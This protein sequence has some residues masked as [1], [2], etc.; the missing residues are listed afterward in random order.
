MAQENKAQQDKA[1][2]N[3]Q[4]HI[5][6][7]PEHLQGNGAIG[8]YI[9]L[10]GCPGRAKML[11]EMFDIYEEAII[12]PRQNNT[13]LGKLKCPE[14]GRDI[15]VAVTSTGM[16]PASTEIVVS[17]LLSAG[18]KRFL[19]VG[20]S[21]SCQYRK[22]RVGSMV[23]ATGAV[24]DE[25][26]SR[27]Y[28]PVEYP[29]I[30][31]KDWVD[32]LVKAS[33]KLGME[34]RTFTG[35]VH[36]KD[37]LYAREIGMGPM[38]ESNRQYKHLLERGNVVSSE[39]E[40]AALFVIS[41]TA[42]TTDISAETDK[43]ADIPADSTSEHGGYRKGKNTAGFVWPVSLKEAMLHPEYEIKAG[44]VLAIIGA[45][46]AFASEEEEKAAVR[47]VCRLAIEGIKEIAMLELK[48][49]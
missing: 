12:T 35:I 37:S 43:S 15:D 32:S 29:A 14:L 2:K 22:I 24:R 10:P 41:S 6:L 42:R 34:A 48:Q 20:T 36:T 44:S 39:M 45:D 27:H 30:A 38:K 1:Q 40:S 49:R 33:Y 16:G 46:D 8:R 19:R 11:S 17:E 13:Y 31:H 18:G 28:M 9:L 21:G 3:I 4:H 5:R 25:N 47:D 26:T 23:I 7:L